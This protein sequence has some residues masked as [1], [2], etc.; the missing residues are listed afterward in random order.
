MSGKRLEPDKGG[1]LSN[2][3]LKRV[4]KNS[5]SPSKENPAKSPDGKKQT[6]MTDFFRIKKDPPITIEDQEERKSESVD[7]F[8]KPIEIVI[9][10]DSDLSYYR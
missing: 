2:E 3:P 4:K 7:S 10:N 9:D 5:S 1:K 6:Q 8:M